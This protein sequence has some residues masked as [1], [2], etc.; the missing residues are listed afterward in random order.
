[1]S[2]KYHKYKFLL[3]ENFLERSRLLLLNSRYNIKH[4][5]SD[6]KLIGLTDP[7]VHTFAA[8]EKRVIITFNDKDFANLASKNPKSGVIGVST[9]MTADHIDKKLASLL[10][11]TKPNEIYGKF[12]YISEETPQPVT[13]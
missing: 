8:K 6:F 4:I 12:I 2:R 1:M 5:K 7:E 3:D 11:K 9:N 10:R 13:N